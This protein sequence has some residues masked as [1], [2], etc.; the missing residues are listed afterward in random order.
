MTYWT[1]LRWL[2]DQLTGPAE[3]DVNPEEEQDVE[4]GNQDMADGDLSPLQMQ[5]V[6]LHLVFV[7]LLEAGFTE[8]QALYLV[9]LAMTGGVRGP[10]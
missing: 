5:A 6:H 3:T 7:S 2:W 8:G 4:Q 1:W 10:E 9:G